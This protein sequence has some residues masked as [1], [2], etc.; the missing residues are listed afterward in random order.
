MK[1]LTAEDLK[2]V[3]IKYKKVKLIKNPFYN[4]R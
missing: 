2:T 4:R 3:K 1:A